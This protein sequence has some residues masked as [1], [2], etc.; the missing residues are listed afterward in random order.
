MSVLLDTC[1]LSEL[2]KPSPMESVKNALNAIADSDLYLSVITIGEL[3]KGIALLPEGNRK[4]DL[5]NWFNDIEKSYYQKILPIDS[6]IATIWGQITA[7]AKN[8]GFTLAIADGLITATAIRHGLHLM[9]R[10]IKDFD[11]T[12]VLLLNPWA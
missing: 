4:H 9:T 10:N 1:V 6:Q 7:K 3:S 12:G 5:Q 11:F 8:Q 2:Y